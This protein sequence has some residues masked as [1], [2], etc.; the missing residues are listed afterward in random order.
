MHHL[1]CSGKINTLEPNPNVYSWKGGEHLYSFT[2]ALGRKMLRDFKPKINLVKKRWIRVLLFTFKLKWT[3]IWCKMR[4]RKEMGFMWALWNKAIALNTW[5]L[6]VNNSIDQTYPLWS[7]GEKS[8][9]HRFWECC[10]AQQA[11][12]Y[13]QNI[14]CELA[15]D[16]KPS[17]V[18]TPLHWKQCDF[19][20]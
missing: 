18:V 11:W 4:S 10:H 3:N 19:V 17:W 6:K 8:M 13:T 1:I 7:N 20:G 5:R 14:V 15:Y 9:L 16:N 2:I 12:Q